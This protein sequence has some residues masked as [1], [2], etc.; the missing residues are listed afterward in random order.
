MSIVPPRESAARTE[1]STWPT[2]GP[3]RC[4]LLGLLRAFAFLIP[5]ERL[6]G[7]DIAERHVVGCVR[8]PASRSH[9]QPLAEG[10]NQRARLHRPEPGQIEESHLKIGAVR[11]VAPQAG[12]VAVVPLDHVRAE[13]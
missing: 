1:S 2:S 5:S 13:L 6:G 11:R 9:V 12:G 4:S 8:L 7:I 10:R 3:R